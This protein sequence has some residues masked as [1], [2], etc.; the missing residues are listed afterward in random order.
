MDEIGTVDVV[1]ARFFEST[2]RFSLLAPD[3][4]DGDIVIL[5]KLGVFEVKITPAEP[6]YRPPCDEC[7]CYEPIL[8][9]CK[10]R[11]FCVESVIIVTGN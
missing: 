4:T 9:H 10:N 8:R 6:Y 11:H 2:D 5:D 7:D 1:G 3:L